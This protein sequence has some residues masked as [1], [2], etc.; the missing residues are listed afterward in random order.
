MFSFEQILN[1]EEKQ[2]LIAKYK[3]LEEGY[4]ILYVKAEF[5]KRGYHVSLNDRDVTFHLEDGRKIKFD[6]FIEK[7]GIIQCVDFVNGTLSQ[8]DYFNRL[9]KQHATSPNLFIIAKDEE[10]MYQYVKKNCFKW[11]VK[12]FGGWEQAKG[13]VT[14][15]FSTLQWLITNEK[16]WET[17]TFD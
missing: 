10:M 4:M 6:V 9:Q 14:F 12:H 15:H 2:D 16:L 11:I 7:D 3:T 1:E 17:I 5:E 8:D 13:K